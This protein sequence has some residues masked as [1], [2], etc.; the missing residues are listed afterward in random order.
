ML[1]Y[2]EIILKPTTAMPA[3]MLASSLGCILGVLGQKHSGVKSR[4]D[5]EP[6]LQ[7]FWLESFDKGLI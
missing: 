4:M 2:D 7:E 1:K 6:F 3:W 5:D